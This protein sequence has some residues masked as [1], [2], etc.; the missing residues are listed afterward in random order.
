M[1]RQA[2]RGDGSWNRRAG[3]RLSRSQGEEEEASRHALL[4]QI[5]GL[6]RQLAAVQRREKRALTRE[7]R[8]REELAVEQARNQELETLLLG[9]AAVTS[10]TTTSSERRTGASTGMLSTSRLATP[11]PPAS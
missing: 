7:T 2:R 10:V 6:Q 4:L 8:V 5:A 1:E 9:P 11:T 3:G